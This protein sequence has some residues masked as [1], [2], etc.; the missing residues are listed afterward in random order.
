LKAILIAPALLRKIR[1]LPANER[2]R[3]GQA[4]RQVQTAIG[5]P[6][7]HRG[8]GLRKLQDEYY[9]VR[10]GLKSQLLFE[11]TT[12]AL[13]FEFLGDHDHVKQFLKS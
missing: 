3:I 7:L 5:T 9:E 10:L 8:L 13:V 11:N 4:I 6:H 1:S 2:K 12:D